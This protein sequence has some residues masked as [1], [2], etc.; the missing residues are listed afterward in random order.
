M[1]QIKV[2]SLVWQE[3]GSS[4]FGLTVYGDYEIFESRA[5]GAIQWI[6]AGGQHKNWTKAESL[7]AAKAACQAHWE[8][9][10]M[11]CLEVEP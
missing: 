11:S 8:A 5:S 1:P 10:V 4:C 6:P 3:I 2:K 7:E 9:A